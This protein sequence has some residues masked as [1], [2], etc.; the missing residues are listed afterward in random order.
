MKSGALDNPNAFMDVVFL[1]QHITDFWYCPHHHL[2][3]DNIN[4]NR[5]IRQGLFTDM[6]DD[7]C[8]DWLQL[9]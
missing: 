8:R 2:S 7:K 9:L 4:N 3:I 1:Y 5:K 6:N